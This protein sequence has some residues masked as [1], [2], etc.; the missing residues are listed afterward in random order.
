MLLDRNASTGDY[1]MSRLRYLQTKHSSILDVRG[2]GLM[3]GVELN[4]DI[5]AKVV[6]AGMLEKKILLNRTH[7]TVLRFLPPFLL[8]RDHV[9]EAI[10]ALNELLATHTPANPMENRVLAGES[11]H[12]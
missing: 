6:L 8:T 10:G 4:S 7:E 9:D 2:F 12:G 1:F 3:I 11:T 5:L